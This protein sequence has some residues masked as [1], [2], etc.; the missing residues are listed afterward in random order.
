MPRE[1]TGLTLAIAGS[2]LLPVTNSAYVNLSSLF[3]SIALKILS[4]R[5]ITTQVLLVSTHPG[6]GNRPGQIGPFRECPRLLEAG[7]T[8]RLAC[9]RTGQSGASRRGRLPRRGRYRI[10]GIPLGDHVE[11]MNVSIGEGALA[12]PDGSPSRATTRRIGGN[13]RYAHLSFSSG[14][15]RNVR[16]RGHM[17]SL[18]VIWPSWSVSKTLKKYSVNCVGSP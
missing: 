6:Y 3:L 9:R 14:S 11:Q 5:Y 10:P 2:C 13:K 16:E 4:T 17:N 12:S 7:R 8:D 18:K 15:P 1:G